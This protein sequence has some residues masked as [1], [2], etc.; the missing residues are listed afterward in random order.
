MP[1]FTRYQKFVVAMLAFLQF[2]IVLDFMILSPLGAVLLRDLGITTSQFGL[3]VSAYA[4]SAGIAG[5]ATAGFADK[6]DRKKLLLFFYTG[7]V[8]GTFLCAM[9]TT[10]HFLLAARIVTGLFGGVIGS[11]S[12]A[13][14]TDLFPLQVRGRVMGVVQTAFA[15]SQVM[16]LPLGL[17]LSNRFS[18]HAPFFMIASVSIA[19]GIAIV[20]VLKPI[21]EHLK[22]QSEHSPLQHL[23]K[24]VGQGRYIRVFAATILLATGG[25]MLMP[26]GSAFT[27][28]NLGIPLEKLP[29]IYMITGVSSIISG[30]IMGRL[31]DAIG[32]YAMF[33]IGS[34][35][36]MVVVGVYCNLGTTPIAWV[37]A[38]NVVLFMAIMARMISVSA[39]TS[40]VPDLKD[41]GAF[42]AIN[43]SLQQLSGGVAASIAGLI[44][45]QSADGRLHN[46]N[47]LGFV[48]MGAMLLTV[49]MVYPIHRAVRAKMAQA[50]ARG[51][52]GPGA[53]GVAPSV[54]GGE[55]A[56]STAAAGAGSTSAAAPSADLQ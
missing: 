31:S 14:I 23:V 50:G 18:W 34:T 6:F 12:F 7:F 41:R 54:A 25:F 17:Y 44:V 5:L 9:A 40:A 47:V 15:A 21:D 51:G 36:G 42:M 45:Y 55:T 11:I 20:I 16:G 37:I 29:L 38:I 22:V 24:T 19:V 28:H 30:P 39:L 32:K 27:V 10:Y 33:A 2:T 53:G 8:L 1:T 56:S 13:I 26:F 35:V 52:M 43:S 3:V 4:F 46:Y 49:A 48:V